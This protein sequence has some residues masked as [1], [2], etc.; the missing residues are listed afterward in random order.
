MRQ[1]L[2][3]WSSG[4]IQKLIQHPLLHPIHHLLR[5]ARRLIPSCHHHSRLL[6]RVKSNTTKPIAMRTISSVS[7]KIG[8]GGC[9][10]VERRHFGRILPLLSLQLLPRCCNGHTHLSP[11]S[12]IG[13]YLDIDGCHIAVVETD[14]GGCVRRSD[15]S[16]TAVMAAAVDGSGGRLRLWWTTAA[17]YFFLP[18]CRWQQRMEAAAVDSERLDFSSLGMMISYRSGGGSNVNNNIIHPLS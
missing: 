10:V 9:V 12:N 8:V 5:T 7:E 17:G 18:Q 14:D 11:T 1:I 6:A 2:V 16:S 15:F 3:L 13:S 4:A